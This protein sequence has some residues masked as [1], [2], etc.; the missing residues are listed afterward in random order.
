MGNPIRLIDPDGRAPDNTIV[1]DD[2]GN[3]LYRAEDSLKDAIVV[4]RQEWAKGFNLTK[5]HLEKLNLSSDEVSK[6][7]RLYGDNYMVEGMVEL[8]NITEH[9]YIPK[10]DHNYWDKNGNK[11]SNINP[12]YSAP[13]VFRD[14]GNLTSV[15]TVDLEK[16]N[17]R[18]IT[19]MSSI[20]GGPYIH[21]HPSFPEGTRAGETLNVSE[22][23]EDGPPGPSGNL[24][25]PGLIAVHF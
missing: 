22:G 19:D 6:T 13:L 7:L 3:E 8:M 21:T 9:T 20:G 25:I 4:V 5:Q 10:N 18:M 15:V 24:D 11:A 1:F 17:T 2:E 14:R 12:E 16:K 23:V